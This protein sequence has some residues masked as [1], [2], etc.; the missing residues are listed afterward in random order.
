MD[1]E[2]CAVSALMTEWALRYL[3]AGF[4]VVPAHAISNT[5]TGECTCGDSSCE[6]PG[7]HPRVKWS[8]YQGRLPTEAEVR[9][10]WAKPWNIAIV[11]GAISGIIVV[12]V[13]HHGLIDGAESLRDCGTMPETPTSRTGGG[14]THYL[15]L[16]PG[17][18][19]ANRAGV[20]PGVDL[21]GDGGYIIAPPSMHASGRAYTWDEGCAPEDV[22]P[23][24]VPAWFTK[25]LQEEQEG[26]PGGSG[27]APL[28]V[29]QYL[30]GSGVIPYR[31]RNVT[32]SRLAGHHLG[33][34]TGVEAT[35]AILLNVY[36]P[37]C[38]VERNGEG[39]P[40]SGKEIRTIVHSIS[41]REQLQR[42]AADALNGHGASDTMGE[43]DLLNVARGVWGGL[44]LRAVTSWWFYHHGPGHH[45]YLLVLPDREVSL[46]D[47][48]LDQ[49]RVRKAML[50]AGVLVSRRK[51]DAWDALALTLHR[52]AV[53][54]FVGPQRQGEV[55]EDWIAEW[56]NDRLHGAWRE[57]EA[58]GR[59]DW[60]KEGP[61]LVNGERV[62]RA[63]ALHAW[64]R[65]THG[66]KLTLNE[67]RAQLK[68]AGWEAKDVWTGS[69][70]AACWVSPMV[71]T[72]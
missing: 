46:G 31:Q 41:R 67:L 16:H 53:E 59:S 20:V 63:P 14:G 9:K 7:K 27:K 42:E 4:S 40:L 17:G 58:S 70:P 34:G 35:I 61:C 5:A 15:L 71:S 52:C 13:D 60:L 19:Q 65:S 68:R 54:V 38:Q 8:E 57:V 22:G 51:G 32:M 1:I 6:S 64:L 37:R 47:N 28:D 50:Q 2:G 66:E 12:D 18:K 62:L 21:R 49:N 33:Q 39:G 44:G 56:L 43:D 26:A 48:L 11:T 45:D 3:R 10:W 55:V 36:N 69:A 29:E 25:L 72:L 23:A 24:A 30:S